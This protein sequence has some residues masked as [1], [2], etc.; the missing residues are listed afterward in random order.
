MIQRK[1]KINFTNHIGNTITLPVAVGRSLHETVTN[2]VKENSVSKINNI[3]EV[4]NPQKP[5]QITGVMIQGDLFVDEA[6]V[7][8]KSS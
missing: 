6:K 2:F 1:L 7:L 3:M 4:T 8:L 5:I